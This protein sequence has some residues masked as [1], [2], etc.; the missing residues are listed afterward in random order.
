[1]KDPP[2]DKVG[3]ALLVLM[4]GVGGTFFVDNIAKKIVEGLFCA[5]GARGAWYKR[6]TQIFHAAYHAAH[7]FTLFLTLWYATNQVFTD[8][9]TTQ[10]FQ[11]L[12]VGVGLAL[13][14]SLQSI[15]AYV[16]ISLSQEIV[17]GCTL[18]VAG[19][20]ELVTGEV[21]DVA[22]FHVAIQQKNKRV[23]YYSNR[24]L[25]EATYVIGATECVG[26]PCEVKLKFGR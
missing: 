5:R 25:L 24:K 20:H 14:D 10:L 11:G 17:V 6:T 7:L 2:L 3:Y 12:C 21:L 1:M 19:G 16:R 23:L 4:A 9:T 15:M 8:H 13:K 18:T 26:P 22:L